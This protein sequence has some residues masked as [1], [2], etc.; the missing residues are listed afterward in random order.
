[1]NGAVLEAFKEI[2]CLNSLHFPLPYPVKRKFIITLLLKKPIVP[3]INFTAMVYDG[4][5]DE[6]RRKNDAPAQTRK[7]CDDSVRVFII[8]IYIYIH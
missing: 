4:S 6:P 3:R 8:Y 2:I 7:I 5:K 1:M